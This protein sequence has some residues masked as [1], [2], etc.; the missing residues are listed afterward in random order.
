MKLFLGLGLG[1][2]RVRPHDVRAKDAAHR[3]LLRRHSCAGRRGQA[4]VARRSPQK[5]AVGAAPGRR[6]QHTRAAHH[7]AGHC[8]HT[9]QQ[10]ALAA[11]DSHVEDM[12]EQF[13][14]DLNATG[15]QDVSE[16]GGSRFTETSS[17]FHVQQSAILRTLACGLDGRELARDESAMPLLSPTLLELGHTGPTVALEPLVTTTNKT[18]PFK[19]IRTLPWIL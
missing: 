12:P 16:K 9:G 1:R 5:P 15:T 14:T 17:A 18:N 2:S 6:Q 13:T 19:I 10:D 3:S 4:D 11:A 8:S 7:V